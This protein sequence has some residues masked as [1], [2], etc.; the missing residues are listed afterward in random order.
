MRK[1]KLEALVRALLPIVQAA[2]LRNATRIAER[3]RLSTERAAPATI[4]QWRKR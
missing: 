1:P 4:A 2:R 3:P